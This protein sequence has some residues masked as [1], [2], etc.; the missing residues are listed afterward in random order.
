MTYWFRRNPR[1]VGIFFAALR[2]S[3]IRPSS[4]VVGFDGL[5]VGWSSR[6]LPGSRRIRSFAKLKDVLAPDRQQEVIAELPI[7]VAL[8]GD[9]EARSFSRLATSEVVE[10][11]TYPEMAYTMTVK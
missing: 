4:D 7:R 10:T 5:V 9:F 6:C 8:L 3:H 2:P 1:R 11:S